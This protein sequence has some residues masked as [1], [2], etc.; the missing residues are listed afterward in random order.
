MH[1]KVS[2]LGHEKWQKEATF[3]FSDKE[4]INFLGIDWTK[5]FMFWVPN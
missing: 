2:E 4:S 5:K 1:I 3:I